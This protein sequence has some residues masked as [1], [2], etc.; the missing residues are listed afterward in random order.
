MSASEKQI[1]FINSLYGTIVERAPSLNETLTKTV[2]EMLEPHEQS[3]TQVRAEEEVSFETAS[4]L[5]SLL[6]EICDL[7]KPDTE[8]RW[9]K[10]KDVWVVSGKIDVIV[11]GAKLIAVSQ[12]KKQEVIIDNVVFSD[13]ETNVAYGTIKKEE[14]PEGDAVTEA[15]FYW[16]GENVIEA[17]HT[18]KGFL[19]ART[20]VNGKKGEYLGKKGLIGLGRKLTLEQ[21]KEYGRKTGVCISCGAELTDPVS[22][23]AGIGPICATKWGM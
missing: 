4:D 7:T 16:K 9:K 13:K 15:G 8:V 3:L 6:L 22:I 10:Y 19:V 5:I 11:P 18:N 17:Y 1:N 20:I 23:E 21:A 2:V 12:K 14:V